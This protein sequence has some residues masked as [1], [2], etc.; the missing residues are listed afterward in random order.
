LGNIL[1][2]LLATSAYLSPI[3][4]A[5]GLF[6]TPLQTLEHSNIWWA[7]REQQIDHIW[8]VTHDEYRG[9]VDGRFPQTRRS[10]RMVMNFG[11][12][13]SRASHSLAPK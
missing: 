8:G 3:P 9:H 5:V 11:S 10:K 7:S 2:V 4:K 6:S 12:H 1:P 13:R